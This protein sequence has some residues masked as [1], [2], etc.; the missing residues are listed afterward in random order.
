VEVRRTDARE[1]LEAKRKRERK[2]E[3]KREPIENEEGEE[4]RRGRR[5]LHFLKKEKCVPWLKKG[6]YT[7]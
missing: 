3:N 5:G 1:M 6:F 4:K 2:E 7:S